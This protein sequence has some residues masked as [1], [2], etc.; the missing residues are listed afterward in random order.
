MP[1]LD[2]IALLI[3]PVAALALGFGAIRYARWADRRP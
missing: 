3:A 2:I 1:Y